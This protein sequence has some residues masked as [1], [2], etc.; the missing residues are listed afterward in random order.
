MHDEKVGKDRLERYRKILVEIVH[1]HVPR[2]TVYLFGSRARGVAREGA[3]IEKEGV[4]WA[5]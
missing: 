2:C 1:S 3:D 5:K 4:L